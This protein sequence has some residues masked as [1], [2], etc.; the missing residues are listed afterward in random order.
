MR[1]RGVCL[2]C[3]DGFGLIGT[4]ERIDQLGG[5]VGTAGVIEWTV[6]SWA[7]RR[8]V[9]AAPIPRHPPRIKAIFPSSAWSCASL[10]S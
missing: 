1:R 8:V 7:A 10:L 2:V 6:A 9:I 3:L 4:A 5:H